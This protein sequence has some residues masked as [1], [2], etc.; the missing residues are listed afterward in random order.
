MIY[1]RSTRIKL[2]TF[3]P[4]LLSETCG[5]GT[6][7][8]RRG[9]YSCSCPAGSSGKRCQIS[10]VAC[11]SNPCQSNQTCYPGEPDKGYDCIDNVRNVA[12][13]FKLDQ[14][15]RPWEEWMKYDVEN[16]IKNAII[17]GRNTA[18]SGRWILTVNT[19]GFVCAS[20]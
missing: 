18:V 3:I 17:D 19:C 9:S 2:L 7:Q 5:N 1:D 8:N 16:E 12:M 15:R 13:V 20:I 6:C 11:R 10:D 4:L 14:S